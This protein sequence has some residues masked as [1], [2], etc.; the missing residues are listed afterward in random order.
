ME[1][2]GTVQCAVKRGWH[3]YKDGTAKAQQ[4]HSKGTAKALQRRPKGTAQTHAHMPYHD[5]AYQT[6]KKRRKRGVDLGAGGGAAEPRASTARGMP[7]VAAPPPPGSPG[8]S[9]GLRPGGPRATEREAPP[10][11][12]AS[13]SHCPSMPRLR[14]SVS[15][16]GAEH[17]GCGR[18]ALQ[19]RLDSASRCA[20]A[21][22]QADA[23][24]EYSRQDTAG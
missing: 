9:P 14:P 15:A 16:A 11:R 10:S 7:P 22:A 5:R 17:A 2:G 18:G 23:R 1:Y 13:E 3:G 6:K 20:T 24:P 8:C 19:G 4:R 12:V 21:K